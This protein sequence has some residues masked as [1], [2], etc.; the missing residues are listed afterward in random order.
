MSAPT[1][2]DGGKAVVVQRILAEGR[3][4]GVDLSPIVMIGDGANDMAARPPADAF[5]AFGGV[6]TREAVRSGA[7]WF[8]T[9]MHELLEV[10][11]GRD[12]SELQNRATD[13]ESRRPTGYM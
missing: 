8:V 10:V 5:I 12:A 3:A 7:D 2:Q 11:E 9:D 6:V 1:S 13:E 4:L